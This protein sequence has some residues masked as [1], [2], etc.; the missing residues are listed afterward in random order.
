[1]KFAWDPAKAASNRR[2][3][4]VSFELACEVFADPLHASRL[5]R[6]VEGEQRW[7]TLG[8]VRGVA[9]LLVAHL[10]SNDHGEET[11]RIISARRASAGERRAYETG[12]F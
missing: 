7:Q 5:D 9:I 11:I 2:K 10:W 3:H 8:M 4:G 1:M 12:D 6:V